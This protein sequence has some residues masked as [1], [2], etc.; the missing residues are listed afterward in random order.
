MASTH[1]GE[2]DMIPPKHEV[3][4]HRTY[5]IGRP[6]T[7]PPTRLGDLQ[8]CTRRTRRPRRW[9]LQEWE[10]QIMASK[11]LG[12]PEH[13]PAGP[14]ASE[15]GIYRTGRQTQNKAFAGFGDPEHSTYRTRRPRTRDLQHFET[16]NMAPTRIGQPNHGTYTPRRPRK[17]NLQD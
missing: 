1:L 15:H 17:W 13:D 5:S 7:Q 10:S 4:Q 14:G 12:P 9:H 2:K 16:Q 11:H 3:P 6:E 8:Q